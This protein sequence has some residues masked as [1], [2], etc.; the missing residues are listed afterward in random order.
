M[1][2]AA[3]TAIL[4]ACRENDGHQRGP[5]GPPP[6]QCLCE[7]PK[8]REQAT[9]RTRENRVLCSHKAR[10]TPGPTDQ[11]GKPQIH[12]HGVLR[13]VLPQ[14][15]R[16]INPRLNAALVLT[17]PQ[18]K[19]KKDQIWGHLTVADVGIKKGEFWNEPNNSH[20]PTGTWRILFSFLVPFKL[21]CTF[22]L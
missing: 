18:S 6:D 10:V 1:C 3:F 7:E 15:Q 19:L 16:I 2:W 20:S 11:I 8:V 21:L 14:L 13:R 17:S 4:G 9:E 12:E 5:L 22:F